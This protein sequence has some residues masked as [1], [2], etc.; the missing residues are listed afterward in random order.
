MR[1][2]LLLAAALIASLTAW[3]VVG[4]KAVRETWALYEQAAADRYGRPGR[5]TRQLGIDDD[6]EAW[7]RLAAAYYA[8]LP[9]LAREGRPVARPLQ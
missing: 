8:D 3:S 1:T 2:T 9:A 7:Q 5:I 4:V 6:P